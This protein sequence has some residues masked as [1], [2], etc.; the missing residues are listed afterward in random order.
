MWRENKEE[1]SYEETLLVLTKGSLNI[2]STQSIFWIEKELSFYHYISQSPEALE[3]I[4]FKEKKKSTQCNRDSKI[5]K[6]LNVQFWI[7]T[8]LEGYKDQVI[9]LSSTLDK[10]K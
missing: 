4:V 10:K 9:F 1:S 8:Q 6:W 2:L 7:N 5:Y 3:V